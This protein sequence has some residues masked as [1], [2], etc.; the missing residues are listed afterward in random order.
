MS[1]GWASPKGR[2]SVSLSPARSFVLGV[3]LLLDEATSALDQATEAQFLKNLREHASDRLI[4]FITHHPDVA[5]A[6][7]R[8]LQL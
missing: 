4:I 5:A 1:A 8:T 3:I 7:D 2:R 6:C